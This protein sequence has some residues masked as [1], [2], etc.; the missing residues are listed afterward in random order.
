MI[1]ALAW[2][3]EAGKLPAKP[4][5]AVFG[6]DVYL[7]RESIREVGRVHIPE[8]DLEVAVSRFSGPATSL[9]TVL[10]ELHT[11]PF[12][13]RRR[14]VI[15]EEADPFVSKYRKDLEAYVVKAS[16]SGILV[17]HVKQWTSTTKLAQ[18][19]EKTGLAIDCAGPRET[20]LAT[21]VTELARTRFDAELAPEAARLLLELVG[22]EAGILAVEVEKLG[23][24][25]G[26]SRRI[27]RADVVKLVGAGRIETI[28]KVLDA[29][30]TGDART[31]LLHLD[32]VLGAGEQPTPLLAAMSTSLLKVHSAGRLRT[33]RLSLAEACDLAGIPHFAV[34]KTGKQHAHLGPGRVDQLPRMLLQ[35]DLDLKG[36]SALDPR[37]ILE[38]LLVR[39]SQPRAD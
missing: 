15:V 16:L 5:Y 21:W 33:T 11:L 9:A 22:P 18:L 38:T 23:V 1:N 13:S 2:L 8:E 31:A 19:V 26:D 27:E 12:F 34:T 37:L 6:D 14:L 36:A 30:T 4:V 20:E 3:R 32:N 28:W 39:L 25:V 24:F 29:A 35:A 10:D 17:L 7:V